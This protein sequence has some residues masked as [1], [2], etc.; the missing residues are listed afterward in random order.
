M[1]SYNLLRVEDRIYIH[2]GTDEH[3]PVYQLAYDGLPKR[4]EIG[5][6][7]IV[8]TGSTL[9]QEIRCARTAGIMI[10]AFTWEATGKTRNY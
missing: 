9:L 2:H 3:D 6:A 10:V 7:D 1:S 4:V 5:D 8:G